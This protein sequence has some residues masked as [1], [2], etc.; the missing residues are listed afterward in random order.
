MQIL[1]FRKRRKPAES[2][3]I[4]V[5]KQSL[6]FAAGSPLIISQAEK[7]N[8]TREKHMKYRARHLRR[9]LMISVRK[10]V[11]YAQQNVLVASPS[12]PTFLKWQAA[13][14]FLMYKL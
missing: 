8:K 11:D 5:M 13:G 14:R 10:R 2:F 9:R 1:L 6:S 4:I 3:F 12:P 7:W